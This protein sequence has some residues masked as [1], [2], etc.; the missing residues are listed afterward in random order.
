MLHELVFGVFPGVLVIKVEKAWLRFIQVV[1]V[2]SSVKARITGKSLAQRL[3]KFQ[4]A[5]NLI[6]KSV[7]TLWHIGANDIAVSGF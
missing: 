4:G 6:D 2:N 1:S 3:N 7:K 5:V